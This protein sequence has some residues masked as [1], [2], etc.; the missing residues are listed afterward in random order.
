MRLIKRDTMFEIRKFGFDKADFSS[1]LNYIAA[2]QS[3][4]M[5]RQRII[6]LEKCIHYSLIPNFISYQTKQAKR[7]N[8][9]IDSLVKKLGEK[10]CIYERNCSKKLLYRRLHQAKFLQ[11]YLRKRFDSITFNKIEKL[12][13]DSSSWVTVSFKCKLKAK[14][15]NLKQQSI[16]NVNR[17]T[18]VPRMDKAEKV[19]VNDLESKVTILGE[20]QISDRQ[21]ALLALGPNFAPSKKFG[22]KEAENIKANLNRAIYSLRWKVEKEKKGPTVP[23]ATEH[24]LNISPFP[25]SRLS[26][27][28]REEDE[29]EQRIKDFEFK[30]D[31]LIKKAMKRKE[32]VNLSRVE[33]TELMEL[34]RRAIGGDLRISRSDK[35]GEF[36][37]MPTSLDREIVKR[38]LSDVTLYEKTDKRFFDNSIS[39]L[40]K[41]WKTLGSECNLP[42][43]FIERFITTNATPPVL[44]TLVKTHKLTGDCEKS[45]EAEKY[46]IRPIIS[47]CNGPTDKISWVLTKI[48]S[49]ILKMIP[50]H[51]SNVYAL[52]DKINS[53]NE[54]SSGNYS[55]AS[56]DV[57]ALYTNVDN[58]AATRAL[59]E[60]LIQNEE[61][62]N[63]YGFTVGAIIRLIEEVLRSNCF[64]WSGYYY[65]QKR[66]LAMGNRIAPI[67]AIVF[68]NKIES[69]AINPKPILYLRY[70]DDIL[71]ITKNEE[72]INHYYDAIN[73]MHNSIRLT[74][75]KPVHDSLPFLNCLIKLREGKFIT[76]WYRKPTSK[77]IIIHRGSAHPAR[78]K[79]NVLQN[80]VTTAQR[81]CSTEKE[82]QKSVELANK[83]AKE[84]GYEDIGFKPS[85]WATTKFVKGYVAFKIPFISEFFTKAI[86][87]IVK[88][89]NLPLNVIV[90]HP[91]T[92]KNILTMNRV[93]DTGCVERSC[94][95]C[96]SNGEGSCKKMGCIYLIR[97]ECGSEYVGETGRSLTKRIEE[98]IRGLKNPSV[99]SYVD[100]PLARHRVSKHHNK[101][102]NITVKILG[103]ESDP[104]RRKILEGMWIKRIKPAIN[105]KKEMDTSLEL[106]C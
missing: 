85:Y 86:D 48:L 7:G 8:S 50:A 80:M 93:Y 105:V 13:I 73:N 97:C 84:N 6:F 83:I 82:R 89:S 54:D 68:M 27:P 46:K 91:R 59:E 1:V 61:S 58:N 56:F 37:V 51:I 26:L 65:K 41:L 102:P 30:I 2:Y 88:S 90:E 96:R 21:K 81:V 29:M 69:I 40:N 5:L 49:P 100:L 14:L 25:R 43:N 92:L 52:L 64:C 39:K 106:L 72:E 77:N 22:A 42:F 9:R 78:T 101:C 4:A 57:E 44:Y 24:L 99:K 76:G 45:M 104:V 12:S 31:D 60:M 11:D 3:V 18:V 17:I 53:C 16:N 70:I 33:W 34:K 79:I 23:T 55:F 36:T 103:R 10:L 95:I 66:G 71:L 62:I 87:R 19:N 15:Q 75:E 74:I 35:G 63:L 20:C 94:L 38:H 28:P 98:H 67:L 47:A 32:D